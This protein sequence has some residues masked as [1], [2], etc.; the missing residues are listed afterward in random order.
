MSLM[1]KLREKGFRGRFLIPL[2]EPRIAEG[3][4]LTTES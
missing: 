1:P 2:P 3:C 4:R